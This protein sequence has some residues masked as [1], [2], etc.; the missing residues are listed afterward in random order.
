MV[1]WCTYTSPEIAQVGLGEDEARRRGVAF[2]L[3]RVEM[4]EV[5]RAWL[6]GQDEGFLDVLAARGSGRILGATLVAEGAGDLIAP[7]VV[8]VTGASRSPASRRR[9]SV[10]DP[11]RNLPPGGRPVE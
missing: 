1:P 2:D 10:P 7:L 8:A 11:W 9:F 5:D 4:A 3:V 6:A